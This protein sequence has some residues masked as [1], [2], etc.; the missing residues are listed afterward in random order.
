MEW[1]GKEEGE[2]L[3]NRH[4]IKWRGWIPL[5]FKTFRSHPGPFRDKPDEW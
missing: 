3:Y 4:Y 1:E 2:R 5:F